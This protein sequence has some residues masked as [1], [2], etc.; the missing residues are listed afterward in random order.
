VVVI[1]PTGSETQVVA[2]GGGQEIICVFRERIAAQPGE[3]IHIAPDPKLVHLFEQE[4][5]RRLQ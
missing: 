5:G 2:K 3:T 4:S 1:E